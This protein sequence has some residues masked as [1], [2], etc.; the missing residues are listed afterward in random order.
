[1]SVNKGRP[2]RQVARARLDAVAAAGVTR[3]I[4][5]SVQRFDVD[6]SGQVL[7]MV[8]H[9]EDL[10]LECVPVDNLVEA[11]EQVMHDPLPDVTLSGTAPK[12]SDDVASYI[13]DF[14]R[15]EQTEMNSGL[16]FAAEGIGA[17][18]LLAPCG[19]D[20]EGGLRRCRGGTAGLS[21]G[22][23]SYVAYRLFAARERID[24]R[25]QRA[26]RTETR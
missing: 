15:R 24:A 25:L 22:Y 6:A 19:R 3:V 12:Y 4:I 10:H 2:L 11:T 21:R 20:V 13:D 23:R 26:E 1:M 5:P 9:A 8:R 14:A 17:E 7:N 18:H 16:A